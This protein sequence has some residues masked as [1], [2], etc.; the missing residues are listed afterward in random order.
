[1][2]VTLQAYAIANSTAAKDLIKPDRLNRLM[3][4]AFKIDTKF[5]QQAPLNG[6]TDFTPFTQSTKRFI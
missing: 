6:W 2:S 1:M 4:T 5:R 3:Y